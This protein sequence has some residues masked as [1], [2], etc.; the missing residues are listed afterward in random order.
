MTIMLEDVY[1]ILGL[2]VLSKPITCTLI[3]EPKLIFERS[4]FMKYVVE[5]EVVHVRGGII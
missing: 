4:E 5:G 1:F 2:P 3:N